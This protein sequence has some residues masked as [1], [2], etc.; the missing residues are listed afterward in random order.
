MT[1]HDLLLAES[2]IV[3]RKAVNK[4]ALR[5]GI[6]PVSV[7]RTPLELA[8]GSRMVAESAQRLADS[9]R[10]LEPPMAKAAENMQRLAETFRLG[11]S[12]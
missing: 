4:M 9:F 3:A 2:R 7:Y 8:I 12:T 10:A 1:D 11:A 5:L 6:A